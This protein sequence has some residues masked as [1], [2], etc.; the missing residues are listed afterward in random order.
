MII[1]DRDNTKPP[2][3]LLH[4]QL[5]RNATDFGH[6][7]GI[8]FNFLIE[9]W[10]SHI[11]RNQ[12]KFSPLKYSP[13]S[14]KQRGS[15][16]RD[17]TQLSSGNILILPFS[18]FLLRTLNAAQRMPLPHVVAMEPSLLITERRDGMRSRLFCTCNTNMP[19]APMALPSREQSLGAALTRLLKTSSSS[20][21]QVRIKSFLAP[22]HFSKLIYITALLP[23]KMPFQHMNR[24]L[25][26]IFFNKK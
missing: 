17:Q 16:R 21:S 19:S 6:R 9:L 11:Y 13:K 20:C 3:K 24:C 5:C 7:P 12:R 15:C 1:G 23:W 22:C 26:P 4:N 2:L 10:A 14:G 25:K 18:L 8:K